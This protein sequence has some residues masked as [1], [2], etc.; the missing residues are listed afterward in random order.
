M[1]SHSECASSALPQCA[2][3]AQFFSFRSKVTVSFVGYC[4]CFFAYAALFHYIGYVERRNREVDANMRKIISKINEL[5]N[6]SILP[7]EKKMDSFGNFE[8]IDY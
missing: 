7:G 4:V 5:T 3:S 8:Q 2:L 6:E 1:L